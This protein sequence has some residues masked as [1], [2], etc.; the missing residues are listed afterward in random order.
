M[1]S[2]GRTT[3]IFILVGLLTTAYGGSVGY[4]YF[5]AFPKIVD[6]I[7]INDRLRAFED[8]KIQD[9]MDRQL[10]LFRAENS[11]AHEYIIGR[12]DIVIKSLARIEALVK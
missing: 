5:F 4:A 6:S 3:W 7:I 8:S 2:N 1:A 12:Q 9:K 10:E 11:K